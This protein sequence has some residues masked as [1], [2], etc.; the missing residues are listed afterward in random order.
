[1]AIVDNAAM[2]VSVYKKKKSLGGPVLNS[3]VEYPEME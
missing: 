3:L 2:N 1:M